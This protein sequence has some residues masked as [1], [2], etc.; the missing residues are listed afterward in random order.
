MNINI[1]VLNM[2]TNKTRLFL[3]KNV[4]HF[5]VLRKICIYGFMNHLDTF[6][7]KLIRH[8]LATSLMY[9][10]SFCKECSN[11]MFDIIIKY[12]LS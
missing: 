12:L 5:C 7:N 10:S 6:E 8:I 2:S 11:T 9:Q 4:H 1:D 3:E